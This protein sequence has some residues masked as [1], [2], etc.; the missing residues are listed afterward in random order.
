MTAPT[1]PTPAT[2]PAGGAD[3]PLLA[4]WTT[5][6]EAP[7]FAAIR[8][9]HFEPAFDAALAEHRAEIDRIATDPAEPTFENTIAA[10]ER[11]GRTL[12]RVSAVFHVLA[13]AHTNDALL[14]LERS[15]SPTLAA[16]A[17]A[18]RTDGRLWARI[19]ALGDGH[20]LPP[21]D[22]RVLERY[23]LTF[24]RSG[25]GLDAA[26]KA[27]LAEITT[28]LA[29]L[30]TTFSQNVLADEQ[31]WVLLL[32]EA[33]LAGLSASAREE[34]K[35]AAA[36]RGHA[37]KYAVTLARSSVEGFLRA[38]ERRDLREQAFRAWAAR[39]ESGG[40][41][42]NIAVI[43]E[44]VR[45]RAE[46]ARLLG[47]DSFAAFRLEDAMAKTPEAVRTLL[48]RV[49][50]PARARALADRDAM[51]EMIRQEGGNFP[52]AAWDWRFYAEKL[53]KARYGIDEDE[54][55][56]YLPLERMIAAAFDTATRLFGL[57]FAERTD[58]PV[59]HPDV[60]AWEVTGPAGQKVGLF[61]GD[62][63]ARSSKRSGAWMTSLRKQEKLDGA[64][65][66][67]IVNVMNFA[68]PAP[69]EPALLSFD[70]ARTLFH[71]FGHALHG[72][73]SDVTWPTISGTSVA[74][75]F[76]EL[77]S[78]LY[79]H[80]MEHPSV[81]KGFARHAATG[82]PMPDDLIARLARA[83]TFGQG[84]AT[85]EYVAS[86]LVDLDLHVLSPEQAEA[87]DPKAFERASLGRIGMPDEIVMRHRTPHFTHVFSGGGYAAA[88]YSYM[89]SEVLDAD[90]FAAFEETGDVF[91]PGV[92]KR[93]KDFVYAAGG[94]RDPADA[95]V[96]FRGRLPEVDAL[97][98][99][100]G[101]VEAA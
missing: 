91:D 4:A 29:T 72:L 21:E 84:F 59:W 101:L 2:T 42:D 43:A 95:Y 48:D 14:A 18:I 19:T 47:Y 83:R 12:S 85:V 16:H 5:P 49:W 34:A 80:W 94:A 75:D 98:K 99:K 36:E 76:V 40:P 81:L 37:G 93:L 52:L 17:N 7:P 65:L 11:S 51:Q 60:R 64:V 86:A 46:R 78:Q 25:A 74:T 3:N 66:P 41:T 1:L 62:Y 79:E 15:L 82:E 32:D 56:P 58:V 68:K 38:A 33:D 92:A 20:G 35:A 57:G 22:A 61:F 55:R 87:V 73:L 89:W 9:E 44:T 23:R 63:F 54:V 30:G 90:A 27:R 100:R 39:G 69:G 13:G 97:L 70:D 88:Y 24:R 77:P 8:P 53:R 31:S 45:L 26:A 71:E 67:L 50:T 28:R 96:A 10:M 6:F